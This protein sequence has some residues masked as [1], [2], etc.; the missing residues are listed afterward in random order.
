MPDRS[1]DHE[2]RR[3]QTRAAAHK[4][5]AKTTDRSARARAGN[6]AL[7]A[8]FE[9]DVDPQGILPPADR[10]KMADSLMRAHFTNLAL[11]K[12]RAK[13]ARI[14]ADE[15]EADAVAADA[16]LKETGGSAA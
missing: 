13:R 1:V 4:S 16:E 14:I 6:R 8:R 3:L 2:I 9:R 15:L 12:A 5:W 10:A 11:R 7:M